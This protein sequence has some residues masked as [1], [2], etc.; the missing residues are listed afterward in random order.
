VFEDLL[1]RLPPLPR[2]SHRTEFDLWRGTYR[3][4][5]APEHPWGYH[6]KEGDGGE[7]PDRTVFRLLHQEMEVESERVGRNQLRISDSRGGQR[8]DTHWETSTLESDCHCIPFHAVASYDALGRIVHVVVND[9]GY[10][11]ETWYG[12]TLMARYHYAHVDGVRPLPSGGSDYFWLELLDARTGGRLVDT[13]AL[14]TTSSRPS[15]HAGGHGDWG[16]IEAVGDALF[17]VVN[18]N[19]LGGGHRYALLP[20]GEGPVWRTV[21]AAGTEHLELFSLV[22]YTDDRLRIEFQLDHSDL[23]VEAPRRGDGAITVSWPQDITL[24]VL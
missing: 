24:P 14:P 1:S 15:F 9:D 10:P 19:T 18:H 6:W 13:R 17:A 16:V 12:E 20:L 22:N 23:V 4:G 7:F 3:D 8:H 11:T 2:T 5:K 21:W